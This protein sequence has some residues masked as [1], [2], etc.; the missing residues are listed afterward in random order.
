MELV[1][2]EIE[3]RYLTTIDGELIYAG[4]GKRTKKL[5]G[6]KVKNTTNGKIRHIYFS[7]I[8]RMKQI[9]GEM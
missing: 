8:A 5:L 6:F 2:E 4:V 3:E 9:L 1:I 7:S